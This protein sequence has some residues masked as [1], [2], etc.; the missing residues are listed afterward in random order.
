[1]SALPPERSDGIPCEID[2]FSKSLSTHH[3][4]A[5][6]R[7]V[8]TEIN[9]NDPSRLSSGSMKAIQK[10][11]TP[12]TDIK[13]DIEHTSRN[14]TR[15][16]PKIYSKPEVDGPIP[17][18]AITHDG[19]PMG[20]DGDVAV[21]TVEEGDDRSPSNWRNIRNNYSEKYWCSRAQATPRPPAAAIS[22]S[23]KRRK[24]FGQATAKPLGYSN[25]RGGSNRL[26]G[27]GRHWL[28][29]TATAKHHT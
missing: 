4:C 1:M 29:V 22:N 12:K 9:G 14:R 2:D 6:G 24:P 26:I 10:G 8:N 28:M 21:T 16:M 20:V 3:F 19:G 11:T 15:S 27:T 7:S 5:A 17:A 25:K 23:A 13:A 18:R